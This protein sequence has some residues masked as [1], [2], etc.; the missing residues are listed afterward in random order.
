[1]AYSSTRHTF[2]TGARPV[3][4]YRHTLRTARRTF[5]DLEPAEHGAQEAPRHLASVRVTLARQFAEI[6]ANPDADNALSRLTVYA[7]NAMLLI[8]AFPVGFAMLIFNVLVGESLRTTCHVLALTGLALALS[9]T[10]T[11]ARILGLG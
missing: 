10:E 6:R 9:N 1:M 8:L 7:L 3:R 5:P 11:A 4:A 2:L